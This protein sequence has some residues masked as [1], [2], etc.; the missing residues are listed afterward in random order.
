MLHSQLWL[1]RAVAATA[2]GLQE[3]V[4]PNQMKNPPPSGPITDHFDGRVFHNA[5]RIEHGFSDLLRWMR[6]RDNHPWQRV[7]GFTPPPA[8]PE[9]VTDMRITWINH[10]TVLIQV[11]GLNVL[12]DP[13]WSDRAGP[14]SALGPHRY[15]PPGIRFDDLPPIDAILISHAHYDHL[16]LATVRR[17]AAAHDPLFVAGLGLAPLL[18]SAGT[19]RVAT[20]DWWHT[21]TLAPGIE[22]HATPAQ[23]WA[24]RSPFDRN[25]TLWVG[26]Y[27]NSRR[28]GIYFAGDTGMAPHFEAIRDRLGAPRI[29]LLPI[30]AY[31]P[32]WFMAQQHMNPADAVTAHQ[33]LGAAQSIGIHFGTFKLSD[34]GQT[35]PIDAL[36]AARERAGLA[37][38]AFKA[39]AF[40][41]C[42]I[43]ES[44]GPTPLE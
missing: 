19:T 31:E 7:A 38:S 23:H 43:P 6:T 36:V 24:N 13:I 20:L 8:P 12:T 32:R 11:D 42:I 14:L 30:G 4:D 18:K 35:A 25:R 29:A 5:E 40:G 33:R 15:H 1:R 41:E 9:R 16:D 39:P 34:E 44:G 17:L 37:A 21:R 28:G 3:Q 27:L 10:S 2:A 22:L 26:Y